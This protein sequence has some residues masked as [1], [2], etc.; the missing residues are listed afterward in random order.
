MDIENVLDGDRPNALDERRVEERKRCLH[1]KNLVVLDDA[2]PCDDDPR[3]DKRSSLRQ[4]ERV[5]LERRRVVEMSVVVLLNHAPQAG[6]ALGHAYQRVALLVD[7]LEVRAVDFANDGRRPMVVIE[8]ARMRRTQNESLTVEVLGR[9][10]VRSLV[11]E[12]LAVFV[13]HV[14]VRRVECQRMHEDLERSII[15]TLRQHL[16]CECQ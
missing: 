1:S 4:R 10:D 8:G 12:K 11:L 15:F 14:G 3:V 7:A 16:T 2:L 6:V 9:D 13:E 5:S